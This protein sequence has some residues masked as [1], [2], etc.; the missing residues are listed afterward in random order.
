[1]SFDASGNLQAPA[2]KFGHVFQQ[3]PSVDE[4]NRFQSSPAKPQCS[5]QIRVPKS[6]SSLT[7]APSAHNGASENSED[8]L[9]EFYSV[10]TTPK[11]ETMQANPR[12]LSTD[13]V[14]RRI[15]LRRC[16]LR[17][18]HAPTSE[19]RCKCFG[20]RGWIVECFIA[21]W[22]SISIGGN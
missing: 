4:A 3:R 8:T 12:F 6:L 21:S 22:R 15:R 20:N 10:S 18:S 5:C 14:C 11:R 16:L 17:Q 13:P 2:K 1:M 9:L 7:Q 19:T